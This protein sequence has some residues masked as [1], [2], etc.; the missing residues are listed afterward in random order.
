MY[1]FGVKYFIATKVYGA[2]ATSGIPEV[3]RYALKLGKNFL[4]LSEVRDAIELVNP[5]K[6]VVLSKDYGV[7]VNLSEYIRN[8]VGKTM[9][10]FSGLDVSP[11]KD[12]VGLGEAVYLAGFEQKLPPTAE[13]AIILYHIKI[14]HSST[15]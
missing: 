8:L 11:G 1:S 14:L 12:I 15:Q 7:E 5:D 6:V 13:A 10:V 3:T 2:A 4:V 9:I